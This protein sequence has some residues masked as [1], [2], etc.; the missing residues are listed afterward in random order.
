M[1]VHTVTIPAS[2]EAAWAG[3]ERYVAGLLRGVERNPLA[4]L[5]GLEPRAGFERSVS[6]PPECLDLTALGRQEEW[7]DSPEG[8]P[9]TPPYEWWNLHDEYDQSARCPAG[10]TSLHAHSYAEFPG[11]HGR[12]YR[13]LVIGTRAHVVATNHM[14][15]SVRRRSIEGP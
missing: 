1:D 13:A 7:E 12:V 2:R 5:L 6:R 8:Y 4:K 15:R 3:L 9:Q 14:L 11:V 10:S